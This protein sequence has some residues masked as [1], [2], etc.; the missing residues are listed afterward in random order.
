MIINDFVRRKKRNGCLPACRTT[1]HP[2]IMTGRRTSAAA[3]EEE[4]LLP[5]VVHQ[6]M[7]ATVMCGW[8]IERLRLYSSNDTYNNSSRDADDQRR[9][10]QR[11]RKSG[12][13]RRLAQA[14]AERDSRHQWPSRY[15]RTTRPEWC[16]AF[17]KGL[18]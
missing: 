5:S 10:R 6:V 1:A 3:A 16:G 15:T 4:E 14:E 11:R 13:I 9:T 8:Q 7:A 18:C 12:K 2:R 17:K